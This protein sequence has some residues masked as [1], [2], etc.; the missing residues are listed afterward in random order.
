[1]EHVLEKGKLFAQQVIARIKGD[2]A[3]A[4]AAKIARKAL[5]AVESQISGLN[6]QIND[7]EDQV[8]DAKEALDNAIYPS[9]IF[10]KGKDYVAAV[11]RAFEAHAQAESELEDLKT[12][13][14][15]WKEVLDTKF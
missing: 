1:M 9:E 3:E 14:K 8:A 10:E 2:D 15:F 7:Q 11:S 5:C 6:S 13:L 4:T 12:Q